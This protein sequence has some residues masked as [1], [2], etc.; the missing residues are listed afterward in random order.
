MGLVYGCRRPRSRGIARALPGGRYARSFTPPSL[1][2]KNRKSR[3]TRKET[4]RHHNALAY[5]CAQ[6]NRPMVPLHLRKLLYGAIASTETSL[7]CHCIYGNFFMVPLHLRK[8]LYGAIASTE[9][10]LWCHCIY[11]NFFCRSLSTKRFVCRRICGFAPT[12]KSI[13]LVLISLQP[14]GCTSTFNYF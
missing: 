2:P 5:L 11:G 3:P 10:S 1:C 6:I 12:I 8:L 14:F 7:W 4:L 13:V 9:T